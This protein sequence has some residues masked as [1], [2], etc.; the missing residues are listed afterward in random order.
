MKHKNYILF[1]LLIMLFGMKNIYAE[2]CYY[3]TT[4]VSVEYNSNN[5][6]FTIRQR[7]TKTNIL[8]DNEPLI[9]KN[10]SKSDNY[11]G[12]TVNKISNACP[13]YIVYRRKERA[14]WWASDGIWGFD[15]SQ[16]ANSFASASKQ[17]N[18]MSAWTSDKKSITKEE[19]EAGIT[20]N[21]S[22]IKNEKMAIALEG[23]ESTV[24]CGAIFGSK[25]DPSSIAYI[26]NEVLMYPKIIIPILIIIL[27]T[28][29]FFKAVIAQKEDDMKKAQMTFIKR[30]IIGVAIFLIPVLINVIMYLA[31]IVW[32]GLYSSCSI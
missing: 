6:Q 22:Y 29:D 17:V 18:K 30:V 14:L 11:T 10:S 8:A 28:L 15:N 32:E 12:L 7:G 26:I 9:N 20:K 13:N 4:E 1:M 21:V 23:D 31:D 16:D 27:G 5:N 25:D 2:V 3:Q 19:F 24:D